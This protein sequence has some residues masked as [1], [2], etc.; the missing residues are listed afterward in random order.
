MDFK[1]YKLINPNRTVRII[2]DDKI[3]EAKNISAGFTIIDPL[4]STIFHSHDNEEEFIYIMKGKGKLITEKEEHEVIDNTVI[5][6]KPGIKHKIENS[7]KYPLY[8]IFVYSP[9]G[10]EKGIYKQAENEKL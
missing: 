4:S 3:C 7:E 6:I 2:I 9:P 1:P 5:F 10:P 8:F